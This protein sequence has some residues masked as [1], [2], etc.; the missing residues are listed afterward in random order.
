ML[1]LNLNAVISKIKDIHCVCRRG[2]IIKIGNLTIHDFSYNSNP[3][4]LDNLFKNIEEPCI[5]IFGEMKE[6]GAH[7][8]E[9]H[10]QA[11]QIIFDHQFIDKCYVVGN[12]D[13]P[14]RFSS[15]I[16]PYTE[17][18]LDNLN[19]HVYFQGSKSMLLDEIIFKLMNLK[20]P[21]KFNNNNHF[22]LA[23]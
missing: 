4:S 21:L 20:F 10:Q 9:Q 18:I 5:F 14:Q 1:K 19:G 15:K 11:L 23:Q 7:S 13:I 12:I 22:N 2:S 17:N 3:T 6:L 16:Q 8:F